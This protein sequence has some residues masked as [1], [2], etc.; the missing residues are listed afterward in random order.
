MRG[1]QSVESAA[2][3]IDGWTIHYNYF[4]E[5]EGLRNRTPASV[6]GIQTDVNQ[7]DDIARL[8]VRRYLTPDHAT[9][10]RIPADVWN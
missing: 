7:W 1:L 8:D 9:N 4:R 3:L 6:A 2:A 5:H 10:A